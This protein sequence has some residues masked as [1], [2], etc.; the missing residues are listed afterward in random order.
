MTEISKRYR[1]EALNVGRR[2][3][4]STGCLKDP[5]NVVHRSGPKT[6]RMTPHFRSYHN[7]INSAI[8]TSCRGGESTATATLHCSI[9]DLMVEYMV[10]SLVSARTHTHT[11][12]HAHTHEYRCLFFFGFMFYLRTQQRRT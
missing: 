2:L 3:K 8:R 11:H 7:L 9:C 1:S 5:G 10:V 4:A 12:T 6:R